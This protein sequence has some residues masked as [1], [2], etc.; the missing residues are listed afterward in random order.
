MIVNAGSSLLSLLFDL[1]AN[2]LLVDICTD[3][4]DL[5][6]IL[7]AECV[8]S[9]TP[10]LILLV[11]LCLLDDIEPARL[12]CNDKVDLSSNCSCRDLK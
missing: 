10:R 2:A 6:P 12:A 4:F 9:A 3:L 5:C 8:D 11:I 1:L 7:D